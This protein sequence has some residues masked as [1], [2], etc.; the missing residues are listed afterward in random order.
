MKFRSKVLLRQMAIQ[1]TNQQKSK[2]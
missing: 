1:T 2:N